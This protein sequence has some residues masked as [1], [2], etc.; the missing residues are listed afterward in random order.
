MPDWYTHVFT[1][2]M[3]VVVIHHQVRR[4]NRARFI[5]ISERTQT[6]L[7]L[8]SFAKHLRK[9]TTSFMFVRPSIHIMEESDCHRKDSLEISYFGIFN[10]IS[11]FRF[12]LKSGKNNGH[13]PWTPMPLIVLCNWNMLCFVW[14]PSWGRRKSWFIHNLLTTIDFKYCHLRGTYKNTASFNLRNIDFDRLQICC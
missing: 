3:G 9:A 14:G 6:A 2:C 13:F 11:I 10:K 1:V 4:Y 7:Y 8:G 5:D 12:L